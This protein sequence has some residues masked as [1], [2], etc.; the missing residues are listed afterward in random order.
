MGV[1]LALNEFVVDYDCGGYDHGHAKSSVH[2][3]QTRNCVPLNTPQISV[4]LYLL[5]FLSLF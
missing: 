4:Y 2:T 3:E 5:R 1:F